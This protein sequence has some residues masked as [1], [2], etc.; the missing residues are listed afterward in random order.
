MTF[1]GATAVPSVFAGGICLL[2][3]HASPP[4]AVLLMLTKEASDQ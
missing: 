4:N 2:I 3:P 1:P